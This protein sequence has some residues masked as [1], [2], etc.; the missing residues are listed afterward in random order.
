MSSPQSQPPGQNYVQNSG[1]FFA[2][3]AFGLW[4]FV[5]P[6]FFGLYEG[7]SPLLV[8]AH[9]T[10]WS[11]LFIWLWLRFRGKVQG[12]MALLRDG[13]SAL[14]LALTGTL[15]FTNW[16]IY[17]FSVQSERLLD[18]SVGYF[19]TPLMTAGFG[20]VFLGERPRRLQL[21]ALC[22]ATLG[23]LIYTIWLGRLPL[24]ALALSLSFSA[25][26]GI[27]KRFAIP[28]ERG[29]AVETLLMLPLAIGAIALFDGLF[30]PYLIAPTL[31][32]ALWLISAGIVTLLPL[33]WYNAAA[34]RMPLISLGLLQFIVPVALFILSLLPP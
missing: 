24:I 22:L 6:Y 21:V 30:T 13:K 16:G 3:A 11:C 5:Q 27:R 4:G 29:M 18:A 20:M 15:I 8:V 7:M 14:I 19:M 25:Y 17:I 33:V 26:G 23:V 9:R 34:A 2:L 31:D 12:A 28:A 32:Q 1:L 10:I